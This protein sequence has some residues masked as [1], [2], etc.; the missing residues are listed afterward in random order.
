VKVGRYV[1]V[2]RDVKVFLRDHPLDH[3]SMHPFFYNPCFGWI[4]HDPVPSG[5]LEIGHDSWLGARCIITSKCT[6][7][8]IGAVVGAGSIV[9]RDVPDFAIV[10]GNPARILRYRFPD[11]TRRRI[12]ES[13]WWDRSVLECV[14]FADEMTQSLSNLPRHSLLDFPRRPEEE[15]LAAAV[16]S[17]PAD[18]PAGSPERFGH[19]REPS[20]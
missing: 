5:R 11:E 7:I 15:R 6:R 13:H 14:Q 17:I 18:F 1:S 8:G 3:L 12:I 10:A 16:L 20:V 19:S 9:T 4:P 2:A